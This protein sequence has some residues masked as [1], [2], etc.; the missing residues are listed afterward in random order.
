MP[1]LHRN[2][3]KRIY[4]EGAEY[5]ITTVTYERYPYFANPILSELFV[6]DM[7]FARDLKQFDLFGYT[8]MPDHVHLLLQ[9]R[10]KFN[11]S[12][13]MHNAK[14][15]FSLEANQIMFSSPK[16]ETAHPNA[17]SAGDDIYHRL[18]WSNVLIDLHRRF[19]G[20]YGIHHNIPHFRW[21]SSFRDHMIRNEDDYLN[22]L[23]Y[24][25]NNAV[26]HGLVK[27]AEEFPWMWIAGMK[28]PFAPDLKPFK[29]EG[30]L[31]R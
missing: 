27:D 16:C 11:Y 15:V 31:R 5:F 3:Q 17:I 24:I 21:Q 25:Y 8:V 14:R 22:H 1:H 18:R 9:P 12:Q 7:W 26:K 23:E 10:G 29:G 4:K 2:S 28:P 30:L 20:S 13:I 19:V 6:R